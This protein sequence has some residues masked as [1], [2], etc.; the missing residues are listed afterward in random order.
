MPTVP[1]ILALVLL[2]AAAYTGGLL[3]LSPP[4]E[5]APEAPGPAAE[6][7]ARA[8]P[9]DLF[10]EH[11]GIPAPERTKTGLFH[12]APDE[13]TADPVDDAMAAAADTPY[14][15]GVR[16]APVASGVLRYDPDRAY[17]GVNLVL[18]AHG[19]EASLRDMKGQVLHTWRY[20]FLDVWPE[21][22]RFYEWSPHKTTWRRVHV[23]PNGD[24]LAIFEGIGM[25]KLDKDSNLLWAHKGR[26]HHDMFVA[27]D[28]TIT[29]LSRDTIRVPGLEGPILEDFVLVLSAEGEPL[30]EVS[31]IDAFR[32]SQYA[33]LLRTVP[34]MADIFHTNTVEVLDGRLAERIPAFAAGNVLVS[35]RNIDTIAVVDL[36]VPRVEWALTG[37]WHLQHQPTVLDDGHMLLF[38][39]LG[40]DGASKVIEFDPLTQEIVWSYANSPET[41][42]DSP[43]SGSC[44]RLPNGNTLITES[45]SGRAFEV[46]RAGEIVWELVNPH[47]AGEADELVA[48]LFEVLR[49]DWNAFRFE[50]LSAA[51]A[52]LQEPVDAAGVDALIKER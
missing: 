39:N 12:A 36:R 20:D 16:P 38:D 6:P 3:L 25:I 22:L 4:A 29:T 47:R 46:T 8:T 48:V 14:H 10:R 15:R 43:H 21:P 18:S 49:F 32:N 24:L 19:P 45:V 1:K 44:Q 42:F 17:D 40:H 41:P 35:V 27:E 37:M 23:F 2:L 9:N 5:P 11:H 28:G 13:G 26:C 51:R 50:E 34:P 33:E 30:R 52:R 7:A 31:L